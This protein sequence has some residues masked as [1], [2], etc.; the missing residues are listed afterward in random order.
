MSGFKM[1]VSEFGPDPARIAGEFKSKRVEAGIFA[2]EGSTPFMIAMVNEYGVEIKVTPKMRGYFAWAF[3]AHLKKTTEKIKIPARPFIG[4]G[5]DRAM[6]G[7]EAIV[8]KALPKVFMGLLSADDFY[9]LIGDYAVGQIHEYAEAL[10]NPPNSE[11][12]IREKGSSKPLVDT[13]FMLQTIQ[14]Q[15]VDN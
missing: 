13:G 4:P 14:W 9:G 12:T 3:G 15:V 11:L 10:A 1:K 7:I 6:D 5:A 8:E 2:P